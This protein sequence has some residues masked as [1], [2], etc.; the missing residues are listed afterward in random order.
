MALLPNRA[1]GR[2]LFDRIGPFFGGFGRGGGRPIPPTPPI[3]PFEAVGRVDG[4]FTNFSKDFTLT[5][6][7]AVVGLCCYYTGDPVITITHGGEPLEIRHQERNGGWLSLIA[8]GS[9]L[10]LESAP[11]EIAAIGGELDG[12]AMRIHIVDPTEASGNGWTYGTQGFGSVITPAIQTGT[13][14]GIVKGALVT[15]GA[16]RYHVMAVEGATNVWSG[17]TTTGSLIDVD[18]STSGPWELGA[19]WSIDGD[20]FVH[21]GGRSTLSISYPQTD[22]HTSTRLEATIGAGGFAIVR[23]ATS[24]GDRYE[25]GFHYVCT[26][27]QGASTKAEIEASGDVRIEKVTIVDSAKIVSWLFCS[28]PAVED[29]VIQFTQ[30]YRP[31]WAYSFAEVTCNDSPPP[32]FEAEYYVMGGGAGGG[33]TPETPLPKVRVNG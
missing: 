24:G 12:G 1:N 26:A 30:P 3:G 4:Y 9:G 29:G 16:D 10:T 27:S 2:I 14:G 28:T 23:Q 7:C 32:P 31:E 17:F 19:G 21:V 11:L 20:A 6:D 22:A 13:V 5:S 8:K 25:E 18:T 15:A 33:L